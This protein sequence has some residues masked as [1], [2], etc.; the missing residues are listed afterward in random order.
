MKVNIIVSVY[1]EEIGIKNFCDSLFYVLDQIHNVDFEVIFVDDGSNDNTLNIIKEIKEENTTFNTQFGA[2]LSLKRTNALIKIISFSKNFGHEAAMLAGIDEA[3]GDY[4]ILMD[5]DLQHPVEKIID[6]LK[7]FSNN[8]SLDIILMKR[9]QNK[10][11]SIIK[12]FTSKSFY[13]LINI[14]S[15]TH[16]EPGVSDFFAFNNKVSTVLKNDY[17]ERVRFLRGFLQNI[18][19]NKKII[20]YEAIKRASGKTHYNYTKL[21]NLSVNSI[22]SFSD[23]PLKLGAFVSAFSFII[24]F[25]VLIYTLCTR[26]NAPSGY[27]TIVILLCFMFAI[28]FLIVGIIGEY[29]SILFTEIK[30]RPSYIIKEIY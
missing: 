17:R 8:N 24:G 28:L 26:G 4:I 18:G 15:K 20:E 25:I 27:A 23:L 10:K 5:S 16:F 2:T 6:I 21:I 14:L 30:K 11:N 22:I 19:F 29:I 13:Y 3:D 1:N 12:N 7:E 9:T